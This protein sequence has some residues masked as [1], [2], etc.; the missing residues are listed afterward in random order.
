MFGGRVWRLI[1]Y[2]PF[3]NR[4]LW[5]WTL[6]GAAGIVKIPPRPPTGLLRSAVLCARLVLR[7][8]SGSRRR[9]GRSTRRRH[10]IVCRSLWLSGQSR[11][12]CLGHLRQTIRHDLHECAERKLII[13]LGDVIRFHPNATITGR[14]ADEFLLWRAV[15]IDAAAKSV[16]IL[17]L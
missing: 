5:A 9:F 3:V 16:R 12:G 11:L 7:D 17:R 1:W 14:P 10:P 4:K 15:N 6:A 13:K 2:W 8:D